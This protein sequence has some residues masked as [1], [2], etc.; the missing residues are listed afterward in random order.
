MVKCSKPAGILAW[1]RMTHD[2]TPEH[3]PALELLYPMFLASSSI[4]ISTIQSLLYYMQFL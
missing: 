4:E 1:S 3:H 2:A